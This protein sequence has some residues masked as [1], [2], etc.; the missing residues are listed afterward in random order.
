MSLQDDLNYVKSILPSHYTV[1]ESKKKYSVH[2]TS[3][4][5]MQ[6]YGEEKE[7]KQFFNKLKEHF[8]S[9][10]QEVF[11][12]VCTNHSDF[13][14]YLKVW[15][16]KEEASLIGMPVSSDIQQMIELQK[17]AREE[18]SKSLG[19]PKERN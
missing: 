17:Q 4:I 3:S 2:C 15:M 7:W 11:H 10:F 19:I 16:S 1:K 9:R 5:G 12:N 14:I 8:G 18:I 13:T 6:D